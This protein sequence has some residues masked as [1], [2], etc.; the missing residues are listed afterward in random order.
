MPYS[1]HNK[2]FKNALVEENTMD[3]LSDIIAL[4]VT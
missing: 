1:I 4:F 3:I 2:S